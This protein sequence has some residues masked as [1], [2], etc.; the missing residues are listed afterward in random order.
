MNSAKEYYDIPYGPHPLQRMDVYCPTGFDRSTPVAFLIHG[1]GF[2]AGMK[3]DFARQA[4][5]MCDEG[6]IVVNISHRLVDTAGIFRAAQGQ[7][8][9]SLKISDQLEDVSAAVAAYRAQAA[10]WGTGEARMFMAGHS[11]GA[12]LAMLYV[13]GDK[14]R[15]GHIL[16]SGNWAGATDLTLSGHGAYHNLPQARRAQLQE[17]YRRAVGAV[18][19]MADSPEGLLISPY[20]VAS[21]AGGR[22]NI[23]VYPE[24]NLVL[25]YPGEAQIGLQ[26]TRSFHELLRSRGIPEQL[27]IYKG[28]DHG[29]RLPAG[30]WQRCIGDT[31]AFF[32]SIG[33]NLQ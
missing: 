30:A 16:G 18:P 2:I 26:Q 5:L 17:I 33:G 14:N 29:F 19:E 32:R 15:D 7:A 24:H 8:L 10:E 9:V 23:S 22:P 20:W 21:R 25:N 6:F 12:I 13:Q 3:E 28:S 4:R 31:A 27:L 1:G 11:A